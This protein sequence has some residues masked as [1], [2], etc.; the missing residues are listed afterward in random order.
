MRALRS[1]SDKSNPYSCPP[2][3]R[4]FAPGGPRQPVET[5]VSLVRAGLN[6]S[7]RVAQEPL[8]SKGPRYHTPCSDG[9]L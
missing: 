3:A 1:S 6:Q 4:V 2:T 7:S 9:T 8:C 5:L